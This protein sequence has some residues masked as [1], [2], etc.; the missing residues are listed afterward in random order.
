MGET[1]P[2]LSKVGNHVVSCM[3]YLALFFPMYPIT[4]FPNKTVIS[5]ISVLFLLVIETNISF[6]F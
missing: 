2:D 4:V 6:D 5:D 1:R 3:E